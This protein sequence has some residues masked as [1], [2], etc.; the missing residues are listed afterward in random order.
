MTC[1]AIAPG[2]IVCTGPKTE[3]IRQKE[4]RSALYC[5]K[6]KR[7]TVQTLVCVAPVMDPETMDEVQLFA[8]AMYGPDFVWECPCGGEKSANVEC[9]W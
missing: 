9:D 7:R 4:Q 6:C 8:A 2:I 1:H 3:R 5:P